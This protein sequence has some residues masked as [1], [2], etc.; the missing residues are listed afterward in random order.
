MRPVRIQLPN[1]P[2]VGTSVS[3]T[4]SGFKTAT[5]SGVNLSAGAHVRVD[6][7]VQVGAASETVRVI[8]HSAHLQTS[9]ATVSNT[10]TQ[11][12][13]QNLPTAGRDPLRL[14]LLAPT[15]VQRGTANVAAVSSPYLGSNVPTIAGGRGEAVSF[16]VGGLN[17]NN[18]VFNTPMEKPPLDSLAEFTI[19]TNNYS[20]EY[21]TR[22]WPGDRG[23]A[24]RRERLAWIRLRLHPQHQPER[25][26]IPHRRE[27]HGPLQPV[28]GHAR[29]TGATAR[30]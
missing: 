28:R 8:A 15:V 5:T 14:A 25:Q 19:L 9:S 26:E 29:W 18:R 20:A 7:S 21:R 23:A 22:G 2:S 16:T 13:I 11:Q 6:L 24:V 30:L 10:I 3:A 12:Q 4:L 27:G 1:S 17:I